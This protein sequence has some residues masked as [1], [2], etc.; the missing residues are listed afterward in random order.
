MGG[1]D[2][3]WWWRGEG[4]RCGRGGERTF[5]AGGGRRGGSASFSFTSGRSRRRFFV[6]T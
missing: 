2:F 6:T 5:V 3:L 4:R 1:L